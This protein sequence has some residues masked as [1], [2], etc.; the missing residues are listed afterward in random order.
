MDALLSVP[1]ASF[2]LSQGTFSGH[3]T[4][5]F[6]YAW[7]KKGLEGLLANPNIFNSD[8]AIVDLGVGKNMVRAIRHWCIATKLIEEGGF[9]P[10]TRTRELTITALGRALF[11]DP[12]FDEY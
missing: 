10:N 4:F 7:L 9:L 8:D 1:S 12:A 5:P 6:R 3:E 2:S 11:I